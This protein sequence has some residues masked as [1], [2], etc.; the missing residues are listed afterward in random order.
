MFMYAS[1]LALAKKLNRIL[2]I[3]D[4]GINFDSKLVII[5]FVS[6]FNIA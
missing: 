5:I 1:A 3:D 6:S 2:L 4:Y